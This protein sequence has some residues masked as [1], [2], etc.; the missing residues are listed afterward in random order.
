MHSRLFAALSIF[1]ALCLPR[2]ARAD[3]AP[4]NPTDQDLAN[5]DLSDENATDDRIADGDIDEQDRAIVELGSHG[6]P[7]RARSDSWISLAGFTRELLSGRTDVGGMVVV[8]LS[9]DR[10]AASPVHR[11]SE[12]SHP[13]PPPPATTPPPQPQTASFRRVLVAPSLA[14]SCVAAALRASGLGVDDS[15]IDAL[16]TRARESAWLPETRMRAMRLVADSSRATT[17]ATTDG[18]SYYDTLG[19]HLVLEL[20]LTWRFDRLVYAGDEP[21]IERT[22]LERQAARARLTERTLEVLFAWQRALVEKE[23]LPAGSEE[24][25]EKRLRA[26]EARATLDVLTDGWFSRRSE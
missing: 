18:T 5:P 14:R 8:G 26:A 4:K 9:L 24:E 17:L 13:D 23:G 12:Q 3:P 10:L 19:T 7:A 22:R 15:L 16:L 21:S 6:R 1:V 11:L 20:R 25:T 2:S